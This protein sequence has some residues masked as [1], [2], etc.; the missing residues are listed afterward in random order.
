MALGFGFSTLVDLLSRIVFLTL[1]AKL[2]ALSFFYLPGRVP[3]IA[4]AKVRWCGRLWS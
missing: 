1:G 2:I 4:L 3:G